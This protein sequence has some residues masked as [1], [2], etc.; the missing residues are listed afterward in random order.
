MS[1]LQ[2]YKCPACGGKLEFEA[3]SQSMKCP[4]CATEFEVEAVKEMQDIANNEDK[5]DDINWQKESQEE[6]SE[7]EI[8]GMRVYSCESCGG[9]IVCEETT[10]SSSCPYCDSPIVMT[11][12]FTGGERPDFIIP[13]KLDK[14][15]A[16]EKFKEHIKGYGKFVPERFK[17]ENHIEE[18]KGLYVPFWLFDA[19]TSGQARYTGIDIRTWSDSSYE[20][21]EK[22]YYSVIREGDLRFENVPADGSSQL[23]DELMQSIEPFDLEESVEFD[24]VYMSGYLADKYDVGLEESAPVANE[25][26][27]NSTAYILSETVQG[28]YDTLTTESCTIQLDDGSSKYVFYPVWILN[29]LYKDTN[30]QFA[31]NGQT[32]KFVGDIPLDIS[33]VIKWLLIYFAGATAIV[34]LIVALITFL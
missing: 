26:I 5:L 18:I 19:H 12:Q 4:Y 30:L 21:T 16:V 27:R 11:G 6:W 24:P 13:F 31:M 7:S 8:E 33:L 1:D 28:K 29:T 3:V 17:D 9:E 32:G 20:Y 15:A 34:Y 14:K 10:A 25:R 23:D 22:S 2:Q